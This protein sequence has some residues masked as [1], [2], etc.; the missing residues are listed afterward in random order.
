MKRVRTLTSILV[1]SGLLAIIPA[2]PAAA[3]DT[4]IVTVVKIAGINWF[5]RMEEGVNQWGEENGVNA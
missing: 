4:D 3:Q 1:A 2:A 5:N